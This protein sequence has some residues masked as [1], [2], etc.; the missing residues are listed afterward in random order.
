MDSSRTFTHHKTGKPTT[1]KTENIGSK[2]TGK[3]DKAGKQITLQPGYELYETRIEQ[4]KRLAAEGN[5]AEQIA[6]E[7]G[8]S[9]SRVR[10]LANKDGVALPEKMIGRSPRIDNRRVIVPAV[11]VVKPKA[12]SEADRKILSE[13]GVVCVESRDPAS[14][15]FLSME[16]PP[17]D[18]NELFRAA[19]LAIAENSNA[20]GSSGNRSLRR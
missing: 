2:K 11:L 10:D 1:M 5:R 3:V 14:V 15:R 9:V 8:I 4:I 13:A 19:I 20:G 12:L 18:S 17:M 16:K 7:L 6:D